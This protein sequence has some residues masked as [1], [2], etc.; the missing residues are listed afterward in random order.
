[1]VTEYSRSYEDSLR[2]FF[3]YRL[4]FFIDIASYPAIKQQ[5]ISAVSDITQIADHA[6]VAIWKVTP[7]KVNQ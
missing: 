7:K 5:L 3:K 4:P 2:Y 1:M 6:T